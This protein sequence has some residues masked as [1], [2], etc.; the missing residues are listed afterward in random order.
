MRTFDC[1][2]KFTKLPD[3]KSK[4]RFDATASTED[5]EAL[6]TLKN[7]KGDLFL[8]YGNIPFSF[9]G[10]V[11]R[12]ASKALTK[13]KNISSVFVPDIR[14]PIGYGDIGQDSILIV[15]NE[16]ETEM[17]LFIAKGQKNH[18]GG[19]YHL[20]LDG[21]LDQEMNLL[22]QKAKVLIVS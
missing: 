3:S 6:E 12:K 4:T 7:A 1:Y 2:Y 8:Y 18:S 22:R 11:R 16:H 21:E 15:F 19:I 9:K 14:V 20:I 17:E 10:D 13:G 5:Y